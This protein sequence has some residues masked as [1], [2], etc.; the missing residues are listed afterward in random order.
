MKS[1]SNIY[2]TPRSL[3]LFLFL[4]FAVSTVVSLLVFGLLGEISPSIKKIGSTGSS[5]GK[6][7]INLDLPKT[8]ACPIN[9]AKF[10][11]SERDV[12]ET[13]RPIVAMVEN[14]ADSRPVEGLSHADVV[15]EAV[16]E[17]GITRFMS[18]FYC[19]VS[20][21]DTRIAPVRSSRIYFINWAMEY[22]TNPL[23]TH[24][25]GA[26]AICGDCPG[27]TKPVSQV[28]KEVRAIEKLA[29]IGWR[30]PQGNDFDTTYDSG[31]PV[32]WRDPERLGR[33]IPAEHQMVAS[34]EKLFEQGI[35]R[36][37]AYKD[38]NGKPWTDAFTSWKFV[39]GKASS[40][41]SVTSIS[42]Q[43]WESAH[44][45]DVSWTYDS[46]LNMYKRFN[47]GNP[48]TDLTNNQQIQVSNVVVMQVKERGPVDS[49]KHMYYEV[50]GTGSVKIFQNGIVIDGTWKKDKDTSRTI[51]YDS[52]GAE[53]PFVRGFIWISAIPS[54]ND[55][56]TK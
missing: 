14:H 3:F 50:V 46:A 43:Y 25:G 42:Y 38:K 5:N 4:M 36:G 55:I 53:I 15:Y 11:K 45:Y 51:F 18:V 35:K 39:D 48:F 40:S 1:F 19:G 21:A 47:G 16:A 28:G 8:E 6:S 20:A 17:G 41:P 34:S 13:R 26:N 10:T 30:V 23:Y 33:T 49:E 2:K 24:V 37:F 29:A 44:D 22:G 31:F 56:D 32:F 27:G 54:G 7:K 52:K 9:G 12:W